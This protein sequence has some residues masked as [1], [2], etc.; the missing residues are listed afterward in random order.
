MDEFLWRCTGRPA[1]HPPRSTRAE[2][3]ESPAPQPDRARDGLDAVAV[4]PV[5]AGILDVV[6]EHEAVAAVICSK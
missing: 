6:R 3:K 4:A 1:A 5:A 2:I